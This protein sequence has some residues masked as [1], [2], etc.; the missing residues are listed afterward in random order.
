MKAI[1]THSNQPT[2][3]LRKRSPIVE[4][5]PIVF[6]SGLTQLVQGDRYLI[7]HAL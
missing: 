3:H 5:S 4:T 7:V 2:H 1:A 6:L